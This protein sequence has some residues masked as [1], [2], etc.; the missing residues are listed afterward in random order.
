MAAH[1]DLADDATSSSRPTNKKKRNRSKNPLS[2]ARGKQQSHE[3][4]WFRRTGKG[5][6]LFVLYYAGQPT[7]TVADFSKSCSSGTASSSE[8][9]LKDPVAN[10][11]LSRASKRRNKKRKK[12]D[13]TGITEE[14]SAKQQTAAKESKSDNN[15]TNDQLVLNN[16]SH[17]L[18]AA[19]DHHMVK[20]PTVGLLETFLG[21]MSTPLP[22]T[23]RIRRHLS[24]QQQQ[25]LRNTIQQQFSNGAVTPLLLVLQ[26]QNKNK[27][28]EPWL[29]FQTPRCGKAELGKRH[30]ELKQFLVDGSQNGTIARQE[31]GSMLPVWALEH[32]GC[33]ASL[34][35]KR[36]RI[37]DLCASPGSKTLQAYELALLQ[38]YKDESKNKMRILA[39]DVSESR[40]ETLRD[41]IQRSG[42]V[43]DDDDD[44]SN[45]NLIGYGCQDARH[46]ASVNNKSKLWDVIIC[47]VPCSGDGTIRKDPHIVQLWKPSQ[48]H[49]LHTTQLQILQRALQLVRVGGTICYS[50]CSLNPIENEAVVAAALEQYAKQQQEDDN[51]KTPAVEILSLSLPGLVLHPGISTWRVAEYRDDKVEESN[52]D[53]DEDDDEIPKL[54][55]HDTYEEA[56]RAKMPHAV[57]SM[58][59]PSA[60]NSFHLERCQRL[61]PQDHDS[62]GFFLAVIRKNR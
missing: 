28:E 47:D 25:A 8:N 11:G 2:H 22:V 62:G 50:T 24:D 15:K 41:A 5:F 6:H 21:H 27:E 35:G 36:R 43:L 37:L 55:W 32:A 34:S 42:V 54:I 12:Q 44:K 14:T 52:D 20:D 39:N 23:F 10:K 18:L 40:L 3:N 31:L 17:P 59:P 30:P 60:K 57:P 7:C 29:T 13:A 19:M 45:H 33:F 61:W 56:S 51:N 58:W 16:R 46:F 1:E 53:D 49:V 26:H 48:G 4:I 9:P 38:Y